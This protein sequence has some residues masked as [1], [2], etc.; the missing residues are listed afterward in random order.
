MKL[1]EFKSCVDNDIM[2]VAH[3]V[4]LDGIAMVVHKSN[5]VGALT[6]EQIRDI[7]LGKI[8]NWKEV[9]GAD[10]DII[11]ITRDTN[12]GTFET[13]EKLVMN[14]QKITDGAEV[15]GSNGQSR[16]RVQ[17]TPGAIGYVGLG[18]VE[19]VKDITVNGVEANAKT[20][21][22]GDYPIARPLFMYTNGY[23]KMGSPLYRFVTTYL[24]EE[25]QEMVE[26]IGFVP[27]TSY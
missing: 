8:K 27:V 13:F 3:V 12:S 11:V 10:M 25:G 23:P 26:E 17:S 24:T 15:V 14:K 1:K 4:A 18:F 19:G 5:P 20:I 2:P 9:G 16:S 22:S 6:L 21:Q 7:Y